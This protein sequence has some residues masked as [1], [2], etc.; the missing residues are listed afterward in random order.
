MDGKKKQWTLL[1]ESKEKGTKE[2]N[3]ILKHLELQMGKEL[4]SNNLRIKY[5]QWIDKLRL[6]KVKLEKCIEKRKR[7]QD[8]IKF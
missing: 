3:E 4:S 7:K 1:K 2:T 8:N 5:Q 6:K